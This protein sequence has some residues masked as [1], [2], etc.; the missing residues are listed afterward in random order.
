MPGSL[1]A[2]KRRIEKIVVGAREV[3]ARGVAHLDADSNLPATA[4]DRFQNKYFGPEKQFV[5][6][7]LKISALQN[8]HPEGPFSLARISAPLGCVVRGSIPQ[9]EYSIRLGT[10]LTLDDIELNLIALFQ[11]FISVQLN[12]RV[13]DEYIRPVFAADESI[14][15]GVVEP[16]DLPFVLCHRRAFLTAY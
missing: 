9:S 8:N 14:A 5:T 7:N 6:S 2:K 4:S 12:R 15:L 13:V 11:R 3:P 1:G 10:F 16:L